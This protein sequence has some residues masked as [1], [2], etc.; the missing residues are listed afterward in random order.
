M[1]K[2]EEETHQKHRK[3]RVEEEEKK[4]EIKNKK[5]IKKKTK[6]RERY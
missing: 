5:Q 6:R 2:I 1:K 4:N 3:G